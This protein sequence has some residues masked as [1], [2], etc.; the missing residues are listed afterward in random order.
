MNGLLREQA[1]KEL[2]QAVNR[3]ITNQINSISMEHKFLFCPNNII[4]KC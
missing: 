2:L 1:K 4:K 3:I